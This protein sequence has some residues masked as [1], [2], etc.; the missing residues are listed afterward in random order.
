MSSYLI[1]FPRLIWNKAGAVARHMSLLGGH[2]L[3]LSCF[4]CL[5]QGSRPITGNFV[6]WT[7]ALD[8]GDD[9]NIIESLH[10]DIL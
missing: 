4:H 6:P 1:F 7:S 10:A 9:I 2:S 3:C 5:A 8:L